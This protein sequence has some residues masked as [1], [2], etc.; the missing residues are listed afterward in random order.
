MALANIVRA[1]ILSPSKWNTL[2]LNSNMIEGDGMYETIRI[3]TNGNPNGLPIYDDGYL[4]VRHFNVIK[5]DF[6]MYDNSFSIDIE[7]DSPYFGSLEDDKND[8]DTLQDGVFGRRSLKRSLEMLFREHSAGILIAESKSLG[9]L[10]HNDKFYFTDSHS[11]GAKGSS[12]R[13]A[14]GR[15]CVIEC[16]TIEE[17]TRLC[18]RATGSR[19]SQ[20][21]LDYI[22]V[23]PKNDIMRLEDYAA[24]HPE[25]QLE[26]ADTIPIGQDD[27]ITRPEMP[28]LTSVM[29]PI[30][31]AQPDVEDELE[32]SSNLNEITRKTR[33]NIVNEAH[34]LKS[35]EYAWYF[36]FPYG[37]NGLKQERPVKITPLDYFQYRILGTDTRFQRT[38]YL[39]YALS[40]FEYYRVKSS[41]AA[42]AKKIEGQ[43]GQ[44]E[45]VHLN[46]RNL[47]GS[48]AY[49]RTAL[50]DLIAQIRCLG[51]P[52]YFVTF[53]CNDLNWLDMRKALLIADGRPNDD[54][55]N[56]DSFTTQALVERYPVI[57]SRHFMI[58]VNALMKF[59][60]S[61]TEVFG[62]QLVDFW[63]RI[64]FQN[65]GSPHL[66][67]V[68]WVKD[69][70][71]FTTPEGIE[72]LDRICSCELPEE[73]TELY[74]LVK[75]QMHRHSTTCKKNDP[76]SNICRFSFPRQVCTATRIIAHTSDD[77][78][79]SGG[80]ICLLKRRYEDRWVNNY[81]PTL[82]KLWQANMDIQP[83][84][85][86]ESI[87]FYIAKY[88]SKAEPTEL[89][90]GVAQAILQIRR[91][92]TNISRKLFKICMRILKERQVSACECVYRLA[93]LEMRDSSRKTVF[94]NT[95]K[96]E[97]RYRMIQ[98][99]EIGRASGYAKSIFDR[100]ERRPASTPEYDFDNMSL[101]EFAMRFEAYYAK[102]QDGEEGADNDAYEAESEVTTRR[103]L[104]T[105]ADNTK[106]AVRNTPATVRV[107]HFM[108]AND[109]ENYYYSLLLQYMPYRRE[110]ELI[111]EF[112]T[113]RDA[114]LA[115]EA[116]LKE[117]SSYMET[118][119]ERD[120][121][122][123][124][125]FVQ[126]HAFQVLDEPHPN[127]EDVE[128]EVVIDD[129]MTDEQFQIA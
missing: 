75:I 86:N 39:F 79:R 15:A 94:L 82:L 76:T 107:P 80:R 53:S 127:I 61:N 87:A 14:N 83:C 68:V 26:K 109:P 98:F 114:F 60:R 115:R 129:A 121:Q 99:D 59:I 90:V 45:D 92:E 37:I 19:N 106:M 91:E 56:L 77:F 46:L 29:A 63:W 2:T 84:G 102:K 116:R 122:L 85:S 42:C 74:E 73:N 117:I 33:D 97:Q 125:A 24:E 62:G 30:D 10:H 93:H 105:L 113:A 111:E 31:C 58:R 70:P 124:D 66:H 17:L 95:R 6:I 21:T 103:K 69:H 34:E 78:I 47:R 118:F 52:T 120:R 3:M 4:M 126:V 89:D 18:K 35:E 108:A 65:R 32:V 16:D 72:Q 64:E 101:I 11:C 8:D 81:N 71:P 12:T 104:I 40:M 25:V 49:W 123:E 44:V 119:R 43:D 96:P 5:R 50:N 88:I 51:P 9:V 54:P 36:L 20:Y 67:M 1:A 112:D 128:E 41:I 110:I 27:T 48:S 13:S 57:V 23:H 38:D 28:I 100:Y 7:E 55:K 22:D